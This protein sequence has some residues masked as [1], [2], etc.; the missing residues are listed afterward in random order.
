M[1]LKGVTPVGT[2]VQPGGQQCLIIILSPATKKFT[3]TR[4]IAYIEPI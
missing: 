1:P 3:Q 4:L 2:W